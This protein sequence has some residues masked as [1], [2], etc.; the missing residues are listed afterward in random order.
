MNAKV[1]IPKLRIY[2]LQVGCHISVSTLH[3]TSGGKVCR[4]NNG[5]F[6]ILSEKLF[7]SILSQLADTDKTVSTYI[8]APSEIVLYGSYLDNYIQGRI[9]DQLLLITGMFQK[10][11]LVFRDIMIR[12]YEKGLILTAVKGERS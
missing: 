2:V 8:L 7:T 1:V 9:R 12:D 3:I 5:T 6:D 4:R 11:Q 10:P